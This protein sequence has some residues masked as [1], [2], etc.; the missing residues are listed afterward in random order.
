[1]P[2][3]ESGTV[4]SQFVLMCLRGLLFRTGRFTFMYI[5]HLTKGVPLTLKQL[6][7]SSQVCFWWTFTLPHELS[8]VVGIPLSVGIY[9]CIAQGL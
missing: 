6:L 8:A 2:F 1:M 3:T 5:Y 9:Q 7:F 4:R